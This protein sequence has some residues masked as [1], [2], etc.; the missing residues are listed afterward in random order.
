MLKGYFPL[1]LALQF[2]PPPV[3]PSEANA[4]T[5]PHMGCFH[6]RD[7]YMLHYLDLYKPLKLKATYAHVTFSVIMAVR[8]WTIPYSTYLWAIHLSTPPVLYL[9]YRERKILRQGSTSG[10]TNAALSAVSV[11]DQFSDILTCCLKLKT[12]PYVRLI[13]FFLR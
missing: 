13:H 5:T 3:L 2:R 6:A 4:R 7:V 1:L 8:L 12:G 9:R 11:V 10:T